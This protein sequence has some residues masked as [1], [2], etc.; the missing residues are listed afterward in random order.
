MTNPHDPYN[1]GYQQNPY[2]GG[3][4][5]QQQGGY[6]DQQQY[7]STGGFPAG[8][9]YPNT[10]GFPA[11]GDYP[12]TG[13]YPTGGGYP[14][15]PPK[16]SNTGM[17]VAIVA[18][19]VLVLGTLGITGFV[20]PGFFLSD[21]EKSDSGGGGG[22]DPKS[23]PQAL[24]DKIVA[25]LNNKNAEGLNA[26]K[27]ATAEPTVTSAIN[28]VGDVESAELAGDVQQMDNQASA[29][30]SIT[31]RGTTMTATGTMLKKDDGWC[32]QGVSMGTGGGGGGDIDVPPPNGPN[33]PDISSLP[34]P[35]QSN[36]PP[37]AAKQ[38]IN[39]FV[40]KINSKDAGGAKALLCSEPLGSLVDSTLS[41]NPRMILG[42]ATG[43]PTYVTMRVTGSTSTNSSA[44]GLVAARQDD[45]RWCVG[46]FY[47]S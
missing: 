41:K 34:D 38:V 40:N 9:G 27:C 42:E 16:K 2:P 3:Q 4:G 39:D 24:A 37:E 25:E 15:Q 22:D 10:G 47:F 17:I 33:P 44:T 30:V 23:S 36:V 5:Y 21:D 18:V 13:G 32:W 26:L 6:Y 29:Q 11:G 45:S 8:G 12:P 19:V 14:P 43:S 31:A 35:G 1:Q 46:I 7:P 28:M 20:A